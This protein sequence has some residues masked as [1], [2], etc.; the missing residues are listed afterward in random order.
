MLASQGKGVASRQTW[1]AFSGQTPAESDAGVKEWNRGQTLLLHPPL[2]SQTAKEM[3][4]V[5]LVKRFLFLFGKTGMWV[6]WNVVCI[7]C[8][9]ELKKELPDAG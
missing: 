6:G 3:S 2:D 9:V 7:M 1:T 5:H 4:V 8:T